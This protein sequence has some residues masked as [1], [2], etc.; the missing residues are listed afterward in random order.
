MYAQVMYCLE[1]V[2]VLVKPRPEMAKAE[3]FRTALEVLKADREAL[4]KLTIKH[5]EVILAAT[6]TGTLSTIS[7]PK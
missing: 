1:R 2:A 5:L 6:L 4:A 7:T 3:P